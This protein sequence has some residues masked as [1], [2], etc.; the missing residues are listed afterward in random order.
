MGCVVLEEEQ[1][2]EEESFFELQIEPDRKTLLEKRTGKMWRE[3]KGVN[4]RKGKCVE[5]KCICSQGAG[6]DCLRSIVARETRSRCTFYA[7]SAK[8]CKSN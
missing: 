6:V 3:S 4:E 1:V 7:E 5:E 8:K 2:E